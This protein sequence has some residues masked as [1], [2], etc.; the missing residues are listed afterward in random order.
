VVNQPTPIDYT[1]L[2]TSID[3]KLDDLA[4][5]KQELIDANGT[6]TSI[7]GDTSAIET[8]TDNILIQ[9]TATN[10]KL[11]SI[12]TELENQTV[13][14]GDLKTELIAAN[15]SLDNIET[16]TA[17]IK[18]SLVNI[19]AD[20]ATIKA[21]IATIKVDVAAI[22]SSVAAIEADTEEIKVAV[23]S[24]N[25]KLD[26]VNSNLDSIETKLDTIHSDLTTI[27]STL[28][29]EFDETQVALGNLQTAVEAVQTSFQ[30]VDC[31]DVAESEYKNVLE[32]LS[33][34]LK[35]GLV[36]SKM[37]TQGTAAGTTNMYSQA[38]DGLDSYGKLPANHYLIAATFYATA[39]NTTTRIMFGNNILPQSATYSLI[40]NTVPA[41][42]GQ[43]YLV[44]K[45]APINTS[46][47]VLA[48][49]ANGNLAY[50]TATSPTKG[51]YGTAS[52]TTTA[53]SWAQNCIQLQG[54]YTTNKP[55]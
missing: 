4:L 38:V 33:N 11:D 27:N 29:D 7:E 32:N 20:I 12:Q 53:T 6:L 3:D 44:R 47:G 5:I 21:D 2:L 23:Q 54:I 10:T 25:T 1:T 8:N 36:D 34:P 16:D 49:K 41:T 18:A 17:A 28:Q 22:K 9:V 15:D 42:A 37:Y 45:K 31:D 30:P 51:Y 35:A 43:N 40:N 14:L 48:I 19:E 46:A 39:I 26:T 13:L 55:Y 52:G 50:V 24:I